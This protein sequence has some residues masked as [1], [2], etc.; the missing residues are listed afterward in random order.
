MGLL[1]VELKS[2][3]RVDQQLITDDQI[4]KRFLCV[5]A[6]YTRLIVQVKHE[7]SETVKM[8]ML[9]LGAAPLV[10]YLFSL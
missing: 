7:A 8:A 3:P 6:S 9:Q 4:V 1:S 10:L 2:A 5:L